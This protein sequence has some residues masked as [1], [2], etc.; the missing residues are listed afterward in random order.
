[1][2]TTEF[3]TISSAIVPDRDA[4]IFDDKHINFGELAER[5]NRLAN[6]MSDLGVEAGD[7]VGVMQ[8]NCN[9][10][11][12]TYF[13]TAKLDG[14]LVP[15]NFR[16]R[17]EEL[18]FMLN[19]SGVKLIVLGARYQDMLKSIEPNLT[20]LEHKITLES[21]GEGF[22]FYDDLLA[23]ASDEE[24]FPTADGDD[25]SIIMFTAGTTGTPKG[26]MLS[27]DSFSSYILSNV[28]PVDL[29][30]DEKNILTVPLHHIAGVQ[31][32]MAAIYGG[33]TL[34]L[35]RQFDEEGWMKLV[36][37]EKVNRAMMVPTM[38]KRLMDQPT[39]KDYDLS[40]LQV[41]TYGAAPMPWRS[42]RRPSWSSRAPASST[43]SARRRLHRPSRCFPRTTITSA[44]TTP[45][46]RRSSIA[47]H[48]SAS[49]CR[50]W[51]SELSTRTGTTFPRGRTA[52]LWP[53]AQRLMKG[54]WNRE[55]A[56]RRR[57]SGVAGST[58]VTWATGT[59]TAT[60]SSPAGPR[61]SSS[62]A[63]R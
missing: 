34:V 52:R 2:N 11:I 33:R 9:E 1:M 10:H 48:P 5:V 51:R 27:H 3:L 41:I 18:E 44:K 14:I 45:I 54:Y 8:V 56:T 42:S 21:P 30:S 62:A 57:R 20:T 23:N 25:V 32:V 38:L 28:E 22:H 24:R 49:P 17:S 19:D 31:A 13:A 26:V 55:E 46:S 43:P 59:R 15:I 4:I 61:T 39:F 53:V 40:S 50:T 35:Q 60:F 58:P 12:E 63:A 37:D 29:E 47:S 16:A 6:A 36:Q 7:R